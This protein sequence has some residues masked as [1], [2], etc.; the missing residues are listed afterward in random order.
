MIQPEVNRRYVVF[1]LTMSCWFFYVGAFLMVW[2][3]ES[4][5]C[6]D[7]TQCFDKLIWCTTLRWVF[8]GCIMITTPLCVCTG[9]ELIQTTEGWKELGYVMGWVVKGLGVFGLVY[10]LWN[11]L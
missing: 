4:S 11:L 5:G 6:T 1:R 8:C 2:M 7:R 3:V 9:R 10:L